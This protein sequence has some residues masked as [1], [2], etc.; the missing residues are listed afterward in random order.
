MNIIDQ[1]S[2]YDNTFSPP[3]TQTMMRLILLLA[4]SVATLLFAH[5]THAKASPSDDSWY[6]VL[7]T[8]KKIGYMHM[9]RQ[10]V[11][12]EVHTTNTMTM[13]IDRMGSALGI[14]IIDKHRETKAGKALGFTSQMDMSGQTIITRGDIDGDT[15]TVT[16]E[17]GGRRSSRTTD[18]PKEALLAEGQRLKL[19]DQPAK[20]GTTLNFTGYDTSSQ[21]PMDIK[22]TFMDYEEISVLGQTQRALHSVMNIKL[23]N[24]KLKTDAWMAPETQ[25]MLKSSMPMMGMSFDMVL[26][27]EARAKGQVDRVDLLNKS[28]IT[29]PDGFNTIKPN[30]ALVYTVDLDEAQAPVLDAI[31][32]QTALPDAKKDDDQFTVLIDPQAQSTQQPPTDDDTQP[33]RWLEIKHPKVVAMAKKA[34]GNGGS[35]VTK[36]RRLEQHVRQHINQKN[37]SVGYASAVETID[38]KE[39]DCTEHAVL[40]AALARANGIPAR[41]VTGVAFAPEFAGKKR[42]FVPHAWV[43]AWVKQDGESGWQGFDAAL[44]QF[45]AGHIAF[46]MGNGD[47]ND[48]FNGL[49]IIGNMDIQSINESGLLETKAKPALVE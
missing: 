16:T 34:A 14:T 45:D 19:L 1:R 32:G 25:A 28:I 9:N 39:G 33:S 5:P 4:L 29:A 20:P 30:H 47:P 12:S 44:R 41:V 22:Q 17:R 35:D 11:G 13:S 24:N 43:M 38:S 8:G 2:R 49:N 3:P 7:L 36:M 46:D 18:W 42:I 21:K 23:G 37:L 26:S 6:D 10:V 48:F 15:L 31:P 27:T 40:L